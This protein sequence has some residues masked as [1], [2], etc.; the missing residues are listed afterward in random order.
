MHGDVC[1]ERI[2]RSVAADGEEKSGVGCL[3][4]TGVFQFMTR[5]SIFIWILIMNRMANSLKD[6]MV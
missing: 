1:D 2:Q 6:G 4:S 3:I 5:G